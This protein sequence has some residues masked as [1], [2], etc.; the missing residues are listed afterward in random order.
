[1]LFGPRGPVDASD[2]AA[3]GSASCWPG[4]GPVGGPFTGAVRAAPWTT[5][6]TRRARQASIGAGDLM[7]GLLRRRRATPCRVLADLGLGAGR[8]HRPRAITGA[9]AAGGAAA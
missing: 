1:M 7:L 3:G 9:R 4:A 6:D 2:A 8:R 5:D